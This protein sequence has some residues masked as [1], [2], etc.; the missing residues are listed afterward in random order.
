MSHP[1]SSRRIAA[2]PQGP[3]ALG[4][5]DP[6]VNAAVIE[7]VNSGSFSTFNPPEEVELAELLISLHP[8]CA[9][10]MARFARGGGEID[11]LAAR[12]ARTATGRERI[13][14][15]GYHGWTDWYIAAN[16]A[17]DSPG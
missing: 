6:D 11:M 16:F 12:I 9:G 7:A 10:G 17:D 14:I 1:T 15:C 3:Y 4:A 5:A 8:W 13:A 2:P